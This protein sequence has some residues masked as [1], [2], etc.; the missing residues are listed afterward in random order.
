MVMLAWFW[1]LLA[2]AAYFTVYRVRYTVNE[3][4]VVGTI[5]VVGLGAA[6]FLLSYYLP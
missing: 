3:S 2:I 4:I 5:I 1:V 6:A